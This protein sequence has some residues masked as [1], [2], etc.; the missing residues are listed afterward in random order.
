MHL[1]VLV[2]ELSAEV[3]LQTLIPL[4][5][6][7]GTTHEIRIFQG[8]HDLLRKLPN[9]LA[10]YAN[11]FATDPDV[12]VL[13]LVDRDNDDCSE[14]KRRLEAIATDA[15]LFTKTHPGENGKFSV[16]N[17]IACEELEAWY[18]GDWKAVVA[19]FPRVPNTVPQQAKFRDS[20]AIAGGTFE[21][22]ERIIQRA[23]YYRTGAPKV[24][25]ASLIAPHMVP[26]RNTSP[27][28]RAF[29]DALATVTQSA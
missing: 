9:R 15:G 1:E 12:C 5:T 21:A 22:F 23:G 3:A 26:S 10:G 13:V 20:D 25:S 4:M 24:E 29:Q 7:E 17:R 6:P 18:F 16:I 19:A 14:L 2:E 27:S 11:W 8:K 28:F